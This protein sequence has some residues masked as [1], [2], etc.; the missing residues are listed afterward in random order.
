MNGPQS[1][2]GLFAILSRLRGRPG[3]RSVLG[4]VGPFPVAGRASWSNDWH[5]YRPCPYP[6]LHQGLDMFAARGTPVVSAAD[7]VVSRVG[8]DPISGLAVT[9]EDGTH[10][11]Y[12]YAHLS[13]FAR[14]IRP[15]LAVHSGDILGFIGNTGDAS[16]GPA[17]LHFQVE[18]LGVP[19]P[20][21]PFVDAWLLQS[22]HRAGLLSASAR[23]GLPGVSRWTALLQAN[24]PDS[25]ALFV[26]GPVRRRAASARA[27]STGVGPILPTAAGAA[28]ATSVAVWARRRRRDRDDRRVRP[29]RWPRFAGGH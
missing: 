25:G 8:I 3:L 16:G 26:A 29:R 22:E 19:V 10:T 12:F 4:V 13:S 24:G 15:G 7:A 28:V 2:D 5:A 20:P 9:I 21:K 23:A 1:T 14:G 6:H 27:R 11:S 17:H 18:P